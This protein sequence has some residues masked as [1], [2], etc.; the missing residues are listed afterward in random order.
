ML[1]LFLALTVFCIAISLIK[2]RKDLSRLKVVETILFYILFI[3]VGLS[4][5]MAFYG[6]AFMADKVAATI[7]WAPGSPFQFEV[8]VANLAFGVLGVLCI[9][10]RDGFWLATGIGYATFLFGAAYGHI[11]EIITAGNFAV[12]NAGPILYIGDIGMPSLILILLGLRW[13]LKTSS[14]TDGI[15]TP[16]EKYS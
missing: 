13:K 7:G 4:G 12:N 15:K 9:R 2:N 10:F 16:Y 3:N 5:L 11:R 14:Q 8:A 6:H 1:S